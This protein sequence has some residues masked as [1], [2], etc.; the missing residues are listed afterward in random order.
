M[1]DRFQKMMKYFMQASYNIIGRK[2]GA[3][4]WITSE[5][6]ISLRKLLQNNWNDTLRCI[7][8]GTIRNKWK[9]DPKKPSRLLSNYTSY[10]KHERRSRSDLWIK[11]TSHLP[12][13]S[14]PR[15]A[16]LSQVEM[17]FP[18]RPSLWFKFHTVASPKISRSACLGK[19]NI[20]H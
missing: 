10:R 9:E 20:I 5:Q 14:G 19:P 18:G 6:S 3:T 15:E 1:F 12:R 4:I 11:K 7:I 16:R 2:N 17:V 13:G 8:F